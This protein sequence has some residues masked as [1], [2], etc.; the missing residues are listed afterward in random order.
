MLIPVFL[1]QQ[2]PGHPLLLQFNFGFRP[3]QPSL[4]DLFEIF[5]HRAV[6][7][8]QTCAYLPGAQS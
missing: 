2:Y 1:P 5:L 8:L 3:V 7:N 4:F 6:G